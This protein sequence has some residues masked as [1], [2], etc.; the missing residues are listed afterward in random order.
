M[1]RSGGAAGAQLTEATCKYNDPTAQNQSTTTCDS[2]SFSVG[3]DIRTLGAPTKDP[4][5][6][7]S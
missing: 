1:N 4:N 2:S 5:D 3:M 7:E 6:S